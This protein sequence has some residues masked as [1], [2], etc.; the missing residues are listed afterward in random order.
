MKKF[1][2]LYNGPATPPDQISPEQGK[3]L[4]EAFGAWAKKVGDDLVDFGQPMTPAMATAVSD[5]GSRK[6]P[7]QLNGYSILKADD[8]D[9][10]VEL[11]KDH[12]FLSAKTGEFSVEVFELLPL[13]E[14]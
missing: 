1:M 5:D 14:M 11:V 3:A 12:P 6:D 9:G 2:V 8:L 10:A 4:M 7:L 13:P